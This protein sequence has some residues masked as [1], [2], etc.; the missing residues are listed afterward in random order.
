MRIAQIAPLQVSV[1]PKHYG[2]T[3]RCVSNLTESLVALGHDVTLFASKDSCTSARLMAPIAQAINFAT[4][5]D[6]Q[7]YHI[8]M[9]AEIYQQARSF[10]IIHAH[11][12]GPVLPFAAQ[13]LTP[14]VITL[15]GRL[16]RHDQ[17]YLLRH[18][19]HLNYVAIS[20][21]QRASLADLHWVGMVHHSVDVTSFPFSAQHGD[22]LAFVG[23][24]TPE[25]RPD[26]A[27]AVAKLTGIPLKIAAKIDPTERPYFEEQIQPL[28]DDPLIHFLGEVDEQH[29]RELMRDALA[30]ILPIDWPEPFGMVFIEA[31]ACGTPVL[32]CPCGSVPELL[33]DGVT[34]YIRNTVEALA[35]AAS[36]IKTSI[37]RTR[38]RQYVQ[39]RFDN[40][41]MAKQYIQVYERVLQESRQPSTMLVARH[42]ARGSISPH[43]PA[44]WAHDHNG[45]DDTQ[46]RRLAP[47][48]RG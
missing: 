48:A 41:R 3:E 22:Y 20:Q 44:A 30:L 7:A 15:H 9:L 29:K 1:P 45:Q 14:T 18:F 19:R 28:L 42:I 27:I 32:T 36:H 31:L 46:H 11:L 16:D 33:Q 35:E 37:S 26:R 17:R 13:S 6:I 34:G 47:N 12:D 8:G 43:R 4:D 38:C 2:G 21:S 24:M 39:K 5:V 10:D 40:Q 23:R 25:K